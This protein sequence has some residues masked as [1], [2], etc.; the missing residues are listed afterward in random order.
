M[1]SRL[2]DQGLAT[3]LCELSRVAP[4]GRAHHCM[5]GADDEAVHRLFVAMQPGSYIQPHRHLDPLKTES[6]VVLQGALGFIEF[7]GSGTVIARSVLGKGGP[8]MG[9]DIPPGCWHGI[10]ALDTDTL[11]FETKAG[12]YRALMSQE[13]AAWAPREESPAAGKELLR[14]Q[15]LFN[16]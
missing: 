13:R 5:H 14:L 11:F 8:G 2:F 7:D 4:R 12:P 9:I 3:A 1:L 10:V 16:A 6:L 15:S